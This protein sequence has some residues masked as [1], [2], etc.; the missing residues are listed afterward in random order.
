MF[1]SLPMLLNKI[2]SMFLHCQK[3]ELVAVLI[4]QRIEPIDVKWYIMF[5]ITV[6]FSPLCKYSTNYVV[7][8][9]LFCFI[10]FLFYISSWSLLVLSA[11]AWVFSNYSSSFC[12]SQ[13]PCTQGF[14][15]ATEWVSAV[16]GELPTVKKVVL[17]YILHQSGEVL[18]I[19]TGNW[20]ARTV[21]LSVMP[22][23]TICQ[24]LKLYSCILLYV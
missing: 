3:L 11:P 19:V 13:K 20:S 18:P 16:T 12:H 24:I 6:V 15:E 22:P 1:N 9:V 23:D 14:Q 4:K 21:T 10:F 5:I 2:Y 17:L 8:F 7:L